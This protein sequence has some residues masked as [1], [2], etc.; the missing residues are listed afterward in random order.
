MRFRLPNFNLF[1]RATDLHISAA[2]SEIVAAVFRKES[3]FACE[4]ISLKIDWF[5]NM[6]LLENS[7]CDAVNNP[8]LPRKLFSLFEFSVCPVSLNEE[9][10]EKRKRYP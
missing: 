2:E 9:M 5:E 3:T 10:R 8:F 4:N 1:K 6:L 7:E